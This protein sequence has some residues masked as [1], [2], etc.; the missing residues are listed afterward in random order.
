MDDYQQAERQLMLMLGEMQGDIKSLTASSA[1]IESALNAERARSEAALMRVRG[2]L[3]EKQK[4][5]DERV[6]KLESFRIK[7]LAIVV[8]ITVAIQGAKDGL[9]GLLTKI[10]FL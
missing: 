7:A 5:T 8:G 10:G 3:M 1:R 2:E 4:E 9:V 6:S